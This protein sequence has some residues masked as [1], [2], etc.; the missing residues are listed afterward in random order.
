M[1]IFEKRLENLHCHLQSTPMRRG[2]MSIMYICKPEVTAKWSIFVRLF[3]TSHWFHS[4]FCLF[5]DNTTWCLT[6]HFLYKPAQGTMLVSSIISGFMFW[7]WKIYSFQRLKRT[8]SDIV[9]PQSEVDLSMKTSCI[10]LQLVC[11]VIYQLYT[12]KMFSLNF[13]KILVN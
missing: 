13:D 12:Q 3:S 1:K 8:R 9:F 5:L 6:W 2:M 7:K 11:F 4:V 10:C